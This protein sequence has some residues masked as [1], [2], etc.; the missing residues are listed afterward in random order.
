MERRRALHIAL[1]A[2]AAL[3]FFLRGARANASEPSE[4]RPAAGTPQSCISSE[5]VVAY[6]LAGGTALFS[7][8]PEGLP[9]GAELTVSCGA[10]LREKCQPG[11]SPI[12]YV[13]C[14][15]AGAAVCSMGQRYV[16]ACYDVAVC[17]GGEQDKLF[18]T[19]I[20]TCPFGGL[21]NA[22]FSTSVRCP[23]GDV[24]EREAVLFITLPGDCDR[25]GRLTGEEEAAAVRSVFDGAGESCADLNLDARITAD[26]LLKVTAYYL[27][28]RATGEACVM[29]GPTPEPS[30]FPIPA[31]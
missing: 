23:E 27:R 24:V 22:G 21:G 1:T 10:P 26:E 7:V 18:W 8:V 12:Y 14:T 3:A 13:P 19:A 2:L 29:P 9:A 30:E 6:A 17:P 5:Q 4:L 16:A 25:D 11:E 15:A 20:D 31:S 28:Y